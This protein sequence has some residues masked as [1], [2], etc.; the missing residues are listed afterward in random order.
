MR[1]YFY[2]PPLL[3]KKLFNDF[4][5]NSVNG[6]ILITFDDGPSNY[7][8]RVLK[9]LGDLGIK[10][11]FFLVGDNIRKNPN[12]AREIISEGHSVGNHTFSHKTITKLTNEELIEEVYKFNDVCESELSLKTKYFRPPRGRINFSKS[13]ELKKIGLKTVLW[14][15]LTY[16]Y[17]NNINI[18]KF[19]IKKYLNNNSIVVFHDGEKSKDAMIESIKI[20]KEESQKKGFEIGAPAECLS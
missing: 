18:V 9:E 2:D 1:K 16:D 5:W 19:A 14:S 12:L 3:A 13:R 17:K 7:T 11:L 6:K 10:S 15:L 8:D 4:Y 20:I